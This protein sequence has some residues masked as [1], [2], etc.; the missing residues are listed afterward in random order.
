M[1]EPTDNTAPISENLEKLLSD[2]TLLR[3][4][5]SALGADAAPTS[6]GADNTDTSPAADG[7]S[8]V[9]SDPALMAKLPQVIEILKPMLQSTASADTTAPKPPQ[10]PRDDLLLALKPFL[11]RERAATVDTILRLARL[12]NV[13]QSLK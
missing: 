8:K 6:D 9:L 1:T 12:G 5:G 2:P 7:L 4:I 3:T 10:S 13:L 11:S